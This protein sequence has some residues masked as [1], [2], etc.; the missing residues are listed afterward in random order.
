[1]TDSARRKP[2][3]EGTN[4]GGLE[5]LLGVERA[6]AA[7][8]AR[9][10]EEAARLLADARAE[11][12]QRHDAAL[13]A[14]GQAAN[15]LD[16]RLRAEAERVEREMLERSQA[17]CRHFDAVSDAQLERLADDAL[18]MAFGIVEGASP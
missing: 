3:G 4:P 8:L 6:I 18:A 16:A 11:I 9:A 1:M 14:A 7:E 13:R 10:D 2:M 15:E 17:V 5:E 12:T